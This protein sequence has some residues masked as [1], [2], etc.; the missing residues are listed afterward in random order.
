MNGLVL[1]AAAVLGAAAA[2]GP[3]VKIPLVKDL[4]ITTAVSER[5]GDYEAATTVASIDADGTVHLAIAAEVPDADGGPPRSVQVTRTVQAEDLRTGREYRYLFS[6]GGQE[7]YLGATA[8]GPSAAVLT[9][10]GAKQE[11]SIKLDGEAG[12]LPGLLGGMMGAMRGAPAESDGYL[13]ADGVVKLVEPRPVPYAVIVNNAVRA[14]PAWHVRGRFGEGAHPAEVDWYILADAQN[15]LSL[16]YAFGKDRREVVRIGFPAADETRVIEDELAKKKRSV[17]YGI[18]FD[19]NRAS[20]KPQSEPVLRTI[21]QVMTKNPDWTLLVEGHTDNIGGDAK[22]QELSARRADAVK[23]A[24]VERGVAANRLETAR[25]ERHAR[26]P[27]A[28][29]PGRAVPPVTRVDCRVGRSRLRGCRPADGTCCAL[30][31]SPRSRRGWR[32]PTPG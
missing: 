15:P 12:G 2:A 29:P 26:R 31:P 20:L 30:E 10:L 6:S 19:F 32:A 28:Q 4:T 7:V 3:A 27:R 18:Y 21:A 16:R 22:N 11:A 17:L 24:L 14:L 23:A 8:L 13:T 5:Q 9:D 25:D 1:A